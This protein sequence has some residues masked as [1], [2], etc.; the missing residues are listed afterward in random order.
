MTRFFFLF[1]T[2]LC[3]VFKVQAQDQ[4]SQFHPVSPKYEVRAVWL[5]TIGGLDWPHGYAQSETSRERQKEQLRQLLD[6]YRRAGINTVLLQTR[7]RGTVIYPSALEPWDGC[8]SGMPGKSPG[9]DALRFAIDECHKRG[10]ELHAWVVTIP[11]GKW[12]MT[13]CQRLRRKYPRLIKRIGDEGYMDPESHTTATYLATLCAEITRNYDIDGIHLDYIRYPETWRLKVGKARGRE[14]ITSIVRAIHDSVKA[15]K[16]WVK[17]SCSPVGKA[18][19]LSRYGSRG[20]NAYDAVCQ[21]AQGWLR[22]GLMDQLYPMMYFRDDQF[23]PFA[24][25][26]AEQS[27]GRTVA[28][29][30]GIYF[31]D[32][33]EGKWNIGDVTREMEVLRQIGLGHTFFRGRFLTDNTQG[34]YDF[35][36]RFNATPALIP[37]MSWAPGLPPSKPENLV[38]ADTLLKWE[39]SAPYYNIYSSREWPVDISDPRNLI[40][41][42]LPEN[43][44]R[45]FTPGRNFAVTAI[46]HYG[47]E[48]LPCSYA[49]QRQRLLAAGSCDACGVASAESGVA[50]QGRCLLLPRRKSFDANYVAIET[51]QGKIVMTVSYAPKVDISNLKAGHYVVRSLGRKGTTHRLGHFWFRP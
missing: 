48:S 20:W 18:S 27:G 22:D 23:Y 31:L 39:G 1:I 44:V 5:T 29:G 11:V 25:D 35:T 19:D 43:E 7:V 41:T 47:R 3:F 26:W 15:L 16:P 10:M 49:S 51:L 2:F 32:P 46:D 4:S 13:G 17:M 28:P 14:Y 9:Y 36:C 30:L 24:I 33:R 6:K 38:V 37:P 50:V 8:L 40:A 42:R 45:L 34:I 12:N 21:D